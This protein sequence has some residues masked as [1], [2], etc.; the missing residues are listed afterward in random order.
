MVTGLPSSPVPRRSPGD[1]VDDLRAAPR[2]LVPERVGGAEHDQPRDLAVRGQVRAAGEREALVAERARRQVEAAHGGRSL[3]CPGRAVQVRRRGAE[4]LL[5]PGH[6]PGEPTRA[7][8]DLGAGVGHLVGPRGEIVEPGREPA[9]AVTERGCTVL[10]ARQPGA[11]RGEARVQVDGAVG[12]LARSP[13]GLLQAG[14]QLVSLADPDLPD[15]VA[16]ALAVGVEATG[17]APGQR[18]V[19]HLEP[20]DGDLRLCDRA[21]EAVGQCRCAVAK[22]GAPGDDV[23][24]PGDQPLEPAVQGPHSGEHTVGAVRGVSRPRGDPGGAV[25]E[26]AGPGDEAA[27]VVGPG[28]ELLARPGQLGSDHPGLLPER[29]LVQ[30]RP[31]RAGDRAHRPD[32]VNAGHGGGGLL[33]R[34]EVLGVAHVVVRGDQHEIGQRLVAREVGVHQRVAVVAL[35]VARLD[36]TLVVARCEQREQRGQHDERDQ[37]GREGEARSRHHPS[38]PAVPAAGARRARSRLQQA[39]GAEE[40][41]QRWGERERDAEGEHDADRDRRPGRAEQADVREREAGV[42]EDRRSARSR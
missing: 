41:N 7:A 39:T 17:Q 25:T 4:P 24:A 16:G 34:C 2:G 9:L 32:P 30:P 13:R 18:P 10:G 26:P 33:Q 14:H 29:C 42:G 36:P 8:G 5:Q 22:I 20:V 12:E 28:V 37:P 38:A 6:R 21:V 3:G 31:G 40:R 23:V 27:G 19:G 35:G 1:L 15:A 11:D